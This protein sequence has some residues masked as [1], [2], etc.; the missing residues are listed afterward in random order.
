[1]RV[2]LQP[3]RLHLHLV[4]RQKMDPVGN[5]LAPSCMWR[6]GKM[7]DGSK[8]EWCD[9]TWN[10]ITGCTKISQGCK[11]CYAAELHDRRH[12]AVL[13]GAKLPAQY[14][15]PFG[16]IQLFPERLE[17]P[18]HW[19]KPRRIFVNSTS[20]LFHE[21]VPDEFINQIFAA[22]YLGQQ[23]IFLILTKRPDRMC[24]WFSP[25]GY[26]LRRHAVLYWINQLL[27]VR[28]QKW[29]FDIGWPLSN[30]WLGTSVENLDH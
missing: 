9:T 29:E 22:M 18:R 12:K 15:K 19:K 16:E 2:H 13:N 11:N 26:S 8:I 17:M 1:M 28:D 10:P 7:S 30:V 23:H 6:T 3:L 5:R 21:D 24:K 4:W 27:D 14:A 25:H 20:D